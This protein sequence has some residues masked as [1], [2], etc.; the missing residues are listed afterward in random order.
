MVAYITYQGKKNPVRVSYFVLET[1]KAKL[2]IRFDEIT[3]DNMEV[4]KSILW[5]ALQAGAH[6]TKE[7]LDILEEDIVWVLD[8]CFYEFT[9]LVP[10]FL[11]QMQEQKQGEGA[12]SKNYNLPVKKLKK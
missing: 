4:Y 1:L 5:A 12:A 11:L 6:F 7:T 2:N 8:E 10:K 9:Q 3:E